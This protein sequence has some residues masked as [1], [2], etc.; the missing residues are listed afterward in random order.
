MLETSA[1]PQVRA[2]M[3]NAR[4]ERAKAGRDIWKR[5]FRRS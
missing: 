5:L 4:I 3:E 1:N 2:I